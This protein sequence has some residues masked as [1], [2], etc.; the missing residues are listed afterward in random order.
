MKFNRTKIITKRKV[1]KFSV[2][3]KLLLLLIVLAILSNVSISILNAV[4]GTKLVGL[5]RDSKLL[6]V[7]NEEIEKE[8]ALSSSLVDIQSSAERLGFKKPKDLWYLTKA[9]E[10]AKLP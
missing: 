4:S 9:S 10:V 2:K 7:E 3:V 1:S 8:L 6:F 5:E